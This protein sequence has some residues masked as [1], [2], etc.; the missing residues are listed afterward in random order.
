MHI[1]ISVMLMFCSWAFLL[2]SNQAD[3][4]YCSSASWILSWPTTFWLGIR[5]QRSSFWL[6][7]IHPSIHAFPLGSSWYHW[8]LIAYT[9]KILL[10]SKVLL[11]SNLAAQRRSVQCY[12]LLFQWEWRVAFSELYNPISFLT[13]TASYCVI[14]SFSFLGNPHFTNI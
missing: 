14:C 11:D 3:Y 13:A 12:G 4:V 5:T 9:A 1:V 10:I 6:P 7:S 8:L 2:W